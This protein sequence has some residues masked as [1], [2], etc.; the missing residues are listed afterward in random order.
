MN[1]INSAGF[2]NSDATEQLRNYVRTT[3]I[4]GNTGE[5][6]RISAY[7]LF[8][9]FY[10]GNHW[11]KYNLTMASFNYCAA[12]IDKTSQFLIGKNGFTLN[13]KSYYTES[14]SDEIEQLAE[15]LLTYHWNKNNRLNLSYQMLQ[16]GGV[17]G[18][19]F[20]IPTWNPAEKYCKWTVCDSRH[21][22][23]EFVNGDHNNMK[24]FKVR[25]PLKDNPNKYAVKVHE[26]TKTSIRIYYQKS[27]KYD[28]TDKYEIQEYANPVDF[29]PVVHVQNK[30]ISSEY[31]G[32]SDLSDI[33]KLNKT[34]NELQQTLK[35]IIDYHGSPTTI[36]KGATINN[37]I[38]K[39]GNI[40]SG[41]PAE[42]DISNLGLDVD[43]SAITNYSKELKTSMHELSDI[44][45][46]FLGKLQAISNTSA[47][48][49]ML[50]YQP[51]VQRANQK[52][53]Q[54]GQGIT[55]MNAITVAFI[56]VYDPQNATLKKLDKLSPN[57]G[58]FEK[59]FFVEPLFTYGFPQD[60]TSELNI[61]TTE[62]N[63]GINSRKRIMN[64]LGTK[65]TQDVLEEIR[66]EKLEDAEFQSKLDAITNPQPVEPPAN[67]GE[68]D[69]G[70]SSKDSTEPKP[71]DASKAVDTPSASKPYTKDE[72]TNVLKKHLNKS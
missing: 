71:N 44:P 59:E 30:P 26:Y 61:A 64:R 42:S 52:W 23:V 57:L 45:E 15:N 56:R 6:D 53:Q 43:L 3:Y 41:F 4:S 18:D 22:L 34:Y 49:L 33:L 2:T 31:F 27:V 21:V 1:N 11:R 67:P 5:E 20:M 40:W 69:L 66:Q 10:K 37:A 13:V 35:S 46:N 58:A 62:M 60:K 72:V 28:D 50:T 48:A 68:P 54:Y 32:Q 24:A 36:V 17:T 12:F 25:Q 19:L 51:V 39:V 16:M 7:E 8:F 47:A 55:D 65:N 9:Q 38:K 29:I 14:V 63:L 70:S